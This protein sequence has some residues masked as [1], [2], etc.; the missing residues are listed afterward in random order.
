[1]KTK[2]FLTILLSSGISFVTK[3]QY[4]SQDFSKSAIIT[5]YVSPTEA[6]KFTALDAT[7]KTSSASIVDGKLSLTKSGNAQV[8]FAKTSPLSKADV[9]KVTVTFDITVSSN[10]A[11]TQPNRSAAYFMFG[12]SFTDGVISASGTPRETQALTFSRIGINFTATP[13][14]FSLLNFAQ[15]STSEV[16]TGTQQIKWV[17]NNTGSPLS[18]TGPN[19]TTVSVAQGK[20]D[21]WVGKKLVFSPNAPTS[22]NGIDLGIQNFKFSFE[23]G[24]GTIQ[25]DNISIN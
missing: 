19:G 17:I 13:G 11:A 1:M 3:A 18:Y 21:V 22:S 10:D 14:D 2:L 24:K 5:D 16:F 8:Y 9:K 12:N 4:F 15:N 25:L 23:N 6:N 20:S 7:G